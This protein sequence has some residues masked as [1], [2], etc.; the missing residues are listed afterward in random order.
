MKDNEL[1]CDSGCYSS[2]KNLLAI[3]M[4]CGCDFSKIAEICNVDSKRVDDWWHGRESM[5]WYSAF[6]LSSELNIDLHKIIRVA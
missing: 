2:V 3:C 6:V 4:L 1:H 5:P